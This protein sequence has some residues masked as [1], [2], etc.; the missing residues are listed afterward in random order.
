FNPSESGATLTGG[1]DGAISGYDSGHAALTVGSFTGASVPY[2]STQN[3]TAATLAAALAA[4]F[5]NSPG[6]PAKAEILTPGSTSIH[7]TYLSVGQVGNAP[8]SVASTPDHPVTYPGGSFGGSTTLANGQDSYPSG[9]AHPF[10]TFYHYDALGNLSCVEQHGDAT[11]T[12]CPTTPFSSTSPVPPDSSNP[13]RLRRFG[14]NSLGQLLWASNP[15]SGVITYS[16][17]AD[18]NLLQR[19]S[20]APNQTGTATQT[21]SYCYDPLHRVTGKAYSAQTCQNGQLPAGTGVVSYT[22]DQGTNG[23]GRLTSLSDQGGTGSYTYDVMGRIATEQR[24]IGAISK[25]M[26]YSYYFDGSLQTATYPSGSTITYTLASS[27]SNT[28][29]RVGSVQDLANGI[30]YVTGTGSF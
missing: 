15:E 3:S 17:D 24:T 2:S 7:I 14:Y 12:A 26:S 16:Y 20:P 1:A 6:A 27:G 30:N 22:Y 28:G 4:A 29:G 23:T 5:T 8:A 9:I 18:G 21:I 10:V 13:S 25:S 19:T 11:G